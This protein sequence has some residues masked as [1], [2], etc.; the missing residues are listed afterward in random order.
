MDEQI[1]F[2]NPRVNLIILAITLAVIALSQID[3][4]L[5]SSIQYTLLIAGT[6]IIGIPH[7]ATDGHIFRETRLNKILPGNNKWY[8]YAIYVLVIALYTA[9]WLLSPVLSLIIFLLIAVYHFGQSHLFYIKTLD[10]AGIKTVFY[11]LWGTYI[12]TLPLMFSYAE[13]SPIISEIIG[14]A[15]LSV[16]TVSTWALPVALILFAINGIFLSGL[17]VTQKLP[18]KNYLLEMANLMALGLL[19]YFTPLFIAF[20]TYWAVWHSFNSV[21][22][23]STFL[24]H[25]RKKL[26]LKLF[27][28]KALPL[29]LITFLGIGLLLFITQSFGSKETLL[30]MFFI[31]TAAITLPHSIV[32]E[33]LYK[34][35]HVE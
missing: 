16:A 21:V 31:I 14:F 29:S 35:N 6:I 20:I 33:F 28:K 3:Y 15:P 9:Q 13:A 22:E 30:A 34:E 25:Q 17:I 32:M 27:Y 7:G 2:R 19:A 10:A 4:G 5:S 23:I 1:A 26:N 11:L 24:S 8:F 18:L 12:L